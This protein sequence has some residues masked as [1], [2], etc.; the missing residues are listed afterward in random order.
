[1]NEIFDGT[2][3]TGQYV[4]VTASQR[5]ELEDEFDDDVGIG[6]PEQ[7]PQAPGLNLDV[8]FLGM[9]EIYND[10]Q[11]T[12]PEVS[13]TTQTGPATPSLSNASKR[14]LRTLESSSRRV[15]QRGDNSFNRLA[16][17]VI[18]REYNIPGGNAK[19]E[20]VAVFQNDYENV[21]ESSEFYV[22][23]DKFNDPQNVITFNALKPGERRDGWI[24]HLARG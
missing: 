16:D 20:A 7:I 19:E 12:T 3:A 15:R 23:L 5:A 9:N 22:I 10:S 6:D 11:L 8:S 2:A 4:R 18:E 13:T 17:A 24:R 14:R 1:L 21:L